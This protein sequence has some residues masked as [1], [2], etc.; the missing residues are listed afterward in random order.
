MPSLSNVSRQVSPRA[1]LATTALAATLLAAG[2]GISHA[3]PGA[4][5]QGDGFSPSVIKVHPENGSW[6]RIEERVLGLPVTV[7]I[8]PPQGEGLAGFSI[9]QKG[10]PNAV[11][12]L[13]SQSLDNAD[14]YSGHRNPVGKTEWMTDAERQAV[15]AQCNK[16]LSNGGDIHNTYNTFS[17]VGVKLTTTFYSSP[18]MEDEGNVTVPVECVGAQRRPAQAGAVV[19]Q[20]PDFKVKGIGIRFMTTAVYSQ[21][22][23]PGTRCQM[24][25]LSVT[26]PTTKAG[27]VKFKLWTKV[28]NEPMKSEV[29]DAWSSFK[30]PGKFE[31]SFSRPY[32]VEKTTYIQAKAEEMV[33]PIGLSTEWKDVTVRCTGAGGGGLA[34]PQ[35]NANPDGR[36]H[37]QQL[38]QVNTGIA[39]PKGPLINRPTPTHGAAQQ[40]RVFNANAAMKPNG[41]AR[42]VFGKDRFERTKVHVR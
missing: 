15:I 31:A 12:P 36:P 23:N 29:I 25:R 18:S 11:V 9:Y 13:D 20:M 7:N 14:N 10:L 6:A 39:R 28:G 40:Q 33:N 16:N 35:S 30:G 3:R 5:I 17:G 42:P 37:A 34:S 27:P 24:T 32:R 19:S 2:T 1:L 8:T 41:S 4:V 22:P 38:P 21:Q 26:V